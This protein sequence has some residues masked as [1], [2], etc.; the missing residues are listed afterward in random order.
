LGLNQ[1]FLHL[2]IGLK[3]DGH[4]Q[5]RRVVELGA[6]QLGDA[7]LRDSAA[8]KELAALHGIDAARLPKLPPSADGIAPG[9]EPHARPFYEALGYEYA[10]LDLDGSPG[11]IP[12]DLN[13]DEAPAEHRGRFDLVT[14]FGTTE[15]VANQ[16][17][18]FKVIHDLAAPGAVMIHELPA[19]GNVNH[20][21]FNYNPKFFRMLAEN[22]GYETLYLDYRWT[23][24]RPGLPEEVQFQIEQFVSLAGRPLCGVSDAAL[25][26]AQR[27]T[28]DSPFVPPIDVPAGTVAPN[29]ILAERYAPVFKPRGGIYTALRYLRRAAIL[30]L[31]RR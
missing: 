22:N 21:F 3:R 23:E 5:G 2:M 27:K 12:L 4:L 13:Y 11:A 29:A 31:T 17:N 25:F 7:F 19:Q 20:G 10:C 15:H 30:L 1:Y 24:I 18:A 16:L 28:R 6:Q 26:V 14:N 8:Q 9:A